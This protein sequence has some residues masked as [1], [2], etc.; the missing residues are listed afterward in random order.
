MENNMSGTSNLFNL[1]GLDV[2]ESSSDDEDYQEEYDVQQESSIHSFVWNAKRYCVG[3]QSAI[4]L[5]RKVLLRWNVK[6]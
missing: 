4:A 1:S 6:G 5:E 3:T 2:S